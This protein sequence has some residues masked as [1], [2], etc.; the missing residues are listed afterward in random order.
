MSRQRNNTTYEQHT[1]QLITHKQHGYKYTSG[2]RGGSRQRRWP[3]DRGIAEGG[4]QGGSSVLGVLTMH[5]DAVASA[6][7]H[8]AHSRARAHA[9]SHADT[10]ATQ[11]NHIDMPHAPM[12]MPTPTSRRTH[13]SPR[14]GRARRRRRRR[15]GLTA[16]LLPRSQLF[17][18]GVGCESLP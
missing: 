1:E 5:G 18:F 8:D 7:E 15:L 4:M 12:P 14:R 13:R 6:R 9:H 2:Q 11:S 3:G 17:C 16:S 10:I